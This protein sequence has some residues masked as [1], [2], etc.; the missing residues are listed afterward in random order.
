MT[1]PVRVLVVE[2]NEDDAHLVLRQLRKG[3]L[4]PKWAR[5]DSAEGFASA[6]EGQEWDVVICD[7]SLPHFDALAA[8]EIAR[9]RKGDIPFIIVSG[10]IGEDTAV[11]ALKAGAHDYV[12]KDRLERLPAAVERELREAE[13][14]R[15][16]R[17]IEERFRVMFERSPI[18]NVLAARDGLL[19]QVNDT[20]AAMLGYSREEIEGRSFADLTHPDDVESNRA[21]MASLAAGAE[22]QCFEKRYFH[23]G[24]AVVWVEASVAS[25]RDELGETRFFIAGFADITERKRADSE[26]HHL[27]E[28]LSLATRAARMGVWDWDVVANELIW[29]EQMFALYGLE[30]EDI[31]GARAY[32]A[33]LNGVHPDDRAAT[34]EAVKQALRGERSYDTEFRVVLPSGTVRTLKA[35]ADVF[36]DADGTPLRMTGV[37]YD[38]TEERRR[39]NALAASEESLKEANK[40][41]RRSQRMAKTGTWTF[42]PDSQRVEWSD[43][44]YAMYGIGPAAR[45]IDVS[46][47]RDLVHPD[48]RG[49]YDDIVQRA[50]SGSSP[51]KIDFRGMRPD[52][53]WFHQTTWGEAEV[54]EDGRR[55][56]VGTTQDITERKQAEERLAASAARYQSYID[57]TGQIAWVADA[58]GEVV[59]DVPSLRN[60]TGQSYEQAK[61][62]GWAKALHPDD[63]EHTLRAWNEAVTTQSTYEVEYR[64]RRH[65]GVYRSLLARGF[66]VHGTDGSVREWVGTCVDITE[67]KKAE[68]AQVELEEQLRVSQKME[69]IGSLAGGV[70]HDFNNLL[71]V[72]LSYTG[73]AMET[74]RD[75]DPLKSDLVEVKNAADRAVGLTRQLLAFSRKQV[76]QPVPLD[77]NEVAQ[78]LEKMLRRILGEDIAFVQKLAP[79]LGLTTADPGQIEQVLM[80]LVV[81]ARDAMPDGG[82]LTVG[83]S[84]VEVDEY[85]AHGAGVPPGSYVQI[86]VA[87]TGCGLDESSRSRLFE[88]FFTTKEKG[89]GT[90]LGLATVYG[91]VKQSGGHISVYSELG[92]GAT[93][94]IKLP[95][96]CSAS[97]STPFKAVVMPKAVK[98]TETILIVEDEEALRKVAKRS[99]EAVGY[100]VLTASDGEEAMCVSRQYGGDIHLL[101]TDVVMPRLNGRAVARELLKTRPAVKVIYMSGYT[102]DTISHHGVLDA[103]THFLAKPF[104]STAVTQKVREVLDEGKPRSAR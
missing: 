93:F 13:L 79:N 4:D 1:T 16:H 25:V 32:A 103:G 51:F 10:K 69:A 54:R 71:S 87:D 43:E 58:K 61:G 96:D 14:R 67:R 38:V 55:K 78:G 28:R 70:A 39:Q 36:R 98:G 95:R 34:D 11:A 26:I 27:N 42:D 40:A 9:E 83:T 65:D 18:G 89:K 30:Q 48:D 60:F 97:K 86:A 75:E 41:L 76:L 17:Q 90:G 50:L 84:N 77:L 12:M 3:G 62:F 53:T 21:M 29:D 92:Q 37:N 7:Y 35:A 45:P 74:V 33:W 5:V 63:V 59:E 104:T 81:N 49:R 102:D 2:D 20:F 91:I 85:A 94:E 64:M 31:S 22:T 47:S 88:P 23:K 46:K 8:L 24:G 66:P 101:L 100:R 56:I 44:M 6:L 72:I 19:V 52:G 82:V 15:D 80:N 68:D 99:L 73:F 57:V